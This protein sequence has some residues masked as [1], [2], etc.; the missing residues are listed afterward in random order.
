MRRVW[1]RALDEEQVSYPR[2]CCVVSPGG[3]EGP[4]GSSVKTL[5]TPLESRKKGF[6]AL[7]KSLDSVQFGFPG[8]RGK[9]DANTPEQVSYPCVCCVG[10]F[11][12]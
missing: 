4:S 7:Q 5:Y 6:P 8:F 11:M 1:N 10:I 3:Q 9:V 2:V 12:G